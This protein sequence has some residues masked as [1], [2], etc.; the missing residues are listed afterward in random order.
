MA[1]SMHQPRALE[2]ITASASC[3]PVME[4]CVES[5]ARVPAVSSRGTYHQHHH[6]EHLA[7]RDVSFA[8]AYR[9]K[10][11]GIIGTQRSGEVDLLKLLTR[12]KTTP[13]RDA[14]RC[15]GAGVGS[16]LD[17]RKR[18]DV[19]DGDAGGCSPR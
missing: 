2:A 9:A 3:R 10:L 14:Q 12:I 4:R 5:L 17:S 13:P 6:Q 1:V 7:L 11:L 18:P 19:A 16:L 15:R 8:V